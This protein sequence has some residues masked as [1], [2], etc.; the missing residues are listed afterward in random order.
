EAHAK[1]PDGSSAYDGAF[2]NSG[3]LAG[4]AVGHQFRAD[5][6]AVYQY[7]CRNLPSADE[8]SYPLWNGLPAGA[9]MTLQDMTALVDACTGVEHPAEARSD[10][11]KQNLA[12]IIGVMRFPETMLL[13]HMQAA[14]FL[15][16]EIA[17]RITDG[18]SAFSNIGIA[19][20]G[21]SND[22]ELNRG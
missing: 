6:R 12:N 4:P 9:K 7:Y 15:F 19:Y 22:A 5:L 13:R 10:I 17:E 2:F 20:T 18:R 14:T 1:N 8:P 11:Q 21:S 3:F 16:R